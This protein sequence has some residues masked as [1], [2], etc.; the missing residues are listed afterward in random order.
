MN[1]KRK[2][3]KRRLYISAAVIVLIIAGGGSATAAQ[4]VRHRLQER[5]ST[6]LSPVTKLSG[7]Q[8]VQNLPDKACTPGSV[9]NSAGKSQI[10]IPG[11]SRLVRKVSDKT[12]DEIYMRYGIN[13]P[14]PGRY[15]VDHL[16]SLQL[17]GSNE[18]QNLWPLDAEVKDRK[19]RAE[20]YLKRQV[21]DGKMTLSEA[22]Q[23]IAGDWQAV[24]DRLPAIED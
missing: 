23:Q 22:Q 20:N 7:C 24:H 14:A 3:K 6:T 1:K 11:Y 10:C 13:D 16:V 19:D 18:I 9:W 2:Q 21:C 15:E 5:T 12:K 8:V 4:Q 17:G